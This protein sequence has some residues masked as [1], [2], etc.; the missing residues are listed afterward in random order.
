ML[1]KFKRNCPVCGK[2][3]L[4]YLSDHLLQVHDLQGHERK[5]RLCTG[6]FSVPNRTLEQGKKFFLARS[7]L[8][9]SNEKQSRE[10]RKRAHPVKE[11]QQPIAAA[12]R[13]NLSHDVSMA[14][15]IIQILCSVISFRSLWL[16]QRN[17]GKP[18]L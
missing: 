11:T 16:N 8:Q 18:I 15:K 13:P 3:A 12:K 6:A 5:Q 4:Q 10:L 17:P 2:P 7:G 14:T 9:T 1:Y